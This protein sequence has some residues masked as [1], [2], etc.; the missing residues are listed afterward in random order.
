MKSPDARGHAHQGLERWGG[1]G[2]GVSGVMPNDRPTAPSKSVGSGGG[3]AAFLFRMEL[4]GLGGVLQ[5]GG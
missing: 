4:I 3:F 1:G 5:R 2:G